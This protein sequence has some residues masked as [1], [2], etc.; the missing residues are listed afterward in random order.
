MSA[1]TF[2]NDP[3]ADPDYANDSDAAINRLRSNFGVDDERDIPLALRP[4]PATESVAGSLALDLTKAKS[5]LNQCITSQPRVGY[6]LGAK[7]P[8]HGAVPGTDFTRIDCSG[9]VREAIWHA[10]SPHLD[11]KDGSVVQHEWV[12]QHGFPPASVADGSA[13]DGVI[14]IAFLSPH[15]TTSGVGHVTLIADGR[16]LESHGGLGPDSRPWT[17]ADWQGKCVLFVL[18]AA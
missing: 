18:T 5:F 7:A 15:A 8:F 4:D 11:F 2:D 6:G 16:T 12:A 17:G 13:R 14:R 9:F 3:A 1:T 10:T